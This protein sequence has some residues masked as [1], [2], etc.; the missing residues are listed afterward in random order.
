MVLESNQPTH[1]K[2]GI[3][4]FFCNSQKNRLSIVPKESKCLV[5]RL[6]QL[7][8]KIMGPRKTVANS[9]AHGVVQLAVLCIYV[10]RIDYD[11]ARGNIF[12]T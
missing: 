8:Q 7:P 6:S 9:L 11:S 12:L 10:R 4:F 3:T 5:E 2:F 1:L